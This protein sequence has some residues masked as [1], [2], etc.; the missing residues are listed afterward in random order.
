M[1]FYKL[2]GIAPGGFGVQTVY[3][4]GIPIYSL[5]GGNSANGSIARS[6]ANALQV[7]GK[8]SNGT[9]ACFGQCTGQTAT[10]AGKGLPII[11]S[12]VRRLSAE[13]E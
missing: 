5:G 13:P 7:K 12:A 6:Y 3:D 10:P 2:A 4:T 1:W 9:G 8:S 11:V